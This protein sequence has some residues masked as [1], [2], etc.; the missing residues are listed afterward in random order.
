MAVDIAM[1]IVEV[2]WCW[3]WVDVGERR[4]N[5]REAADGGGDG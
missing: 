4:R 2:G 1:N 3:K 5:G